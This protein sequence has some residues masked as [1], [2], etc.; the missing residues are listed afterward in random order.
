MTDTDPPGELPLTDVA[1]AL[2]DHR[3]GRLALEVADPNAGELTRPH[4]TNYFAV[5]WVR[6]ARDV[7]GRR[8]RHPF[9]AP[10]PAVLRPLPAHPARPDAPVRGEVVQFHAN[11]LCVETFHAEVGCSGVLFNDPYGVPVVVAGRAGEGGGRR[12]D[13]PHAG[14][15]RPERDLAYGEVMLAH[16]KVLLILATQAQGVQGGG[17]RAGGG[18]PPAPG[19]GR[20]CVT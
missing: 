9:A 19:P 13:R 6:R 14:G 7:L 12:P 8:A 16:L 2:Y 11:F 10:L 20:S 15:D 17:V 1:Q 5:Y 18:G 4:R 3:D